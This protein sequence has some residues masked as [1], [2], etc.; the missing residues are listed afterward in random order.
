MNKPSSPLIFIIDDEPHVLAMIGEI[1]S[2]EGYEV[3]LFEDPKAALNTIQSKKPD[4]ILL[5]V[6]MPGMD[7]YQFCAK[8]Q[9][10]KETGLIPV[11]FLTALTAEHNKAKALALG[12]AEYLNKPFQK[13][14]LVNAVKKHL[15][16]RNHWLK[17][18]QAVVCKP[19][20]Q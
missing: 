11:I 13:Q 4:L 10:E 19:S 6:L 17:L 3:N 9:E 2:K 15:N 1:I 8:L 18:W 14:E 12:A 7:G 5:D 16:T 20:P